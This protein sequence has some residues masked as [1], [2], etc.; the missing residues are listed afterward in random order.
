MYCRWMLFR[1]KLKEFMRIL[2]LILLETILFAATLAGAGIYAT[3]AIYGDKVI[4][5]IKVGIVA[6]GED[7]MADMLVRFVGGMDS[8]KD[9]VS[10][11]I[12]SKEAAEDALKTGEIYGAIIVPE[13]IVD[14]I[15]SG[16]NIP[17]KIL[18]GSAYSKIETEVFTQLSRAG[19][20]LLT[21]AQAGIYAADTLCGEN[22][23]ADLIGQT[24]DALNEVYLKYALARS[25]LFREKEVTAVKGVNLTDY[26]V[27]SLLFAFLSF[28]GLAFGRYMQVEMGEREKMFK[29]KGIGAVQQ[30]LIDTAAFSIVFALL[31]SLF[32]LPVYLFVMHSSKSSFAPGPAW[33]MILPLW[34]FVGV[35]IRGLFQILGNQVGSMGVGFTV[36]MVFMFASGV[37]IPSVFLPVWIEKA[38]AYLPYKVWMEGMATALQGRYDIKTTAM[39]LA[40]GVFSLAAGI[41]AA[42]GRAYLAARGKGRHK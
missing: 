27:I 17:A 35:F 39:I 2:P 7:R 18:T 22:G 15:L 34:L 1:L 31:G 26:Y 25:T 32:S 19:A 28:V 9:R 24:E 4:K 8:F 37:F 30:Y 40:V 5:E 23:R 36:L 38:G 11:E 20:S 16:E 13:G 29:C 41:L 6:E 3:R 33:M 21:T 14:S 10:L 12:M 42:M